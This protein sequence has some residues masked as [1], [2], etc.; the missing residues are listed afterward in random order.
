MG[1]FIVGIKVYI[2]GIEKSKC[3]TQNKFWNKAKFSYAQLQLQ[4]ANLRLPVSMH[5]SIIVFPNYI[6]CGTPVDGG[7]P[8]RTD[9]PKHLLILYTSEIHIY[10]T[11][12]LYTLLY[13]IAA[14]F[15]K[16]QTLSRLRNDGT[17]T[18]IFSKKTDT[19]VPHSL[20]SSTCETLSSKIAVPRC[21]LHAS[22]QVLK[23]EDTCKNP[24]L[25]NQALLLLL[26]S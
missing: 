6:D 25:F 10:Y 2:W 22:Q 24:C 21:G 15:S 20:F 3:V 23:A 4:Q 1:Y 11:V 19:P 26:H 9:N 14:L 13:C 17:H 7:T 8:R 5:N 18:Q 16:Q 12:S